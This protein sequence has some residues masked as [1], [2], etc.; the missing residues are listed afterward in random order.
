MVFMVFDLSS[1]SHNILCTEEE[2]EDIMKL[3][4]ELRSDDDDEERFRCSKGTSGDSC[5]DWRMGSGGKFS[6]K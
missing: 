2:M 5:L 6:A 4:S 1:L 3:Q